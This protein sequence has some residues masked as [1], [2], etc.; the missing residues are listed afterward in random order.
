EQVDAHI[1]KAIQE[2]NL[3]NSFFDNWIYS[4][5]SSVMEEDLSMCS[6]Y[7]FGYFGIF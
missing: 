1:E 2:L 5:V 6:K 7:I 3:N 4:P